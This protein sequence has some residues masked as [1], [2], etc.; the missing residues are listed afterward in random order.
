[1]AIPM[2]EFEP[3]YNKLTTQNVA[4]ILGVLPRTVTNYVKSGKLS[5]FHRGKFGKL[6]FEEET[7]LSFKIKNNTQ[8]SG[9]QFPS[10]N[11]PPKRTDYEMKIIKEWQVQSQDVSSVDVQIGLLTHKIEGIEE[12]LI[13]L[14]KDEMSFRLVRIH[15]LKL[16]NE[17]RKSLDFLRSTDTTRYKKAIDKIGIN[18]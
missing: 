14:Q 9:S 1:M 12:K 10:H 7:V 8:K 11:R 6:Y 13:F 5:P 2:E 16:L 3:E 15:L 4:E 17:R 18:I